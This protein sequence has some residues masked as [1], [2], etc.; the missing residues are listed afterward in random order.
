MFNHYVC[1]DTS[2][3]RIENPCSPRDTCLPTYGFHHSLNLT[4]NF[5]LF[6]DTLFQ[7]EFSRN[8]DH[9]EGTLDALMQ[10]AVC[11]SHIGWRSN[12]RHLILI[13]TDGSFHI[14][15]DGKLAGIIEANDGDCH[16]EY[17]G[18]DTFATYVK[19]T[20]QDYPSIGHLGSKLQANNMFVVFAIGGVDTQFEL[21]NKL[22]RE[23]GRSWVAKL[24]DRAQNVLEIISDAYASLSQNVNIELQQVPGVKIVST[25][26][27]EQV[28]AN[29]E[30]CV[31]I[32]L[33]DQAQ[34]RID[35]TL[36]RCISQTAVSEVNVLLYGNVRI[37]IDALC[38]CPC[39]GG[40]VANAA[41][42][43]GNGTYAC[44]ICQC[45]A[46]RFGDRCDCTGE[47]PEDVSACIK[48]GSNT[49]C[50]KRG[51][52]VCGGCECEQRHE[53]RIYGK[54][55]EC[56]DNSCGRV[57]SM[58][59]GGPEKGTCVCNKCQCKPEY[60]G[61]ECECSLSKQKCIKT[62][63]NGLVC[64][65]KGTCDCE[66]CHCQEGYLGEFCQ[67]CNGAAVCRSADC[68]DNI[69]CAQCALNSSLTDLS[70]CSSQCPNGHLPVKTT[71]DIQIISNNTSNCRR[72]VSG[73]YYLYYVARD[74]EGQLLPIYVDPEPICDPDFPFW[75]IIIGIVLAG[76]VIGIILLVIIKIIFYYL[77]YREYKDWDKEVRDAIASKFVEAPKEFHKSVIQETTNP[78]FGLK[79]KQPLD[80]SGYHSQSQTSP[81]NRYAPLQESTN[82]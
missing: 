39:E 75:Y 23:L 16:L 36:E 13:V 10:S 18:E 34:F 45:D 65:G 73:C 14:A 26:L 25:A 66:E 60:T 81:T 41:E 38:S 42:C 44:G 47:A 62:G 82:M 4:Q 32:D 29:G 80:I 76:L 78:A 74:S 72:R 46:G 12:S 63:G 37:E 77:E 58:L 30:D 15:N 70:D 53:D 20:T 61:S 7:Q 71:G 22:S 21:Y 64:S 40:A 5:T 24:E 59:C 1:R 51:Q 17:E 50:S 67:L 6:N 8:I 54:Y 69:R 28:S 68:L 19:S 27:C 56:S 49:V 11:T 3:G 33:G 57:N 52:C 2:F 79:N 43:S 48:E 35:V 55:C 9:P 31:G